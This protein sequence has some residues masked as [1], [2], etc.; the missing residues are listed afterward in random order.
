MFG[1]VGE[2]GGGLCFGDYDDGGY[3]VEFCC[4]GFF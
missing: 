1:L 4:D 3:V 2:V